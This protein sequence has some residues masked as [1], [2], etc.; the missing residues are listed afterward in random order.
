MAPQLLLELLLAA[1]A[2]GLLL[3][4]VWIRAW[5]LCSSMR[6]CDQRGNEAA[7]RTRG[8]AHRAGDC[9]KPLTR[10]DRRGGFSFASVSVGDGH[11]CG[12]TTGNQ[13]VCWGDNFTG[14][15]GQ[16]GIGVSA[17]EVPTRVY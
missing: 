17:V 2:L 14:F 11:A 10:L 15:S 6:H 5:P 3:Q 8:G 13:A 4:G 1:A 9:R 7:K 12:T 16:L